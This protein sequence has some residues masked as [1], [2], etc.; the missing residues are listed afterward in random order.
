MC[1]FHP[2]YFQP[3]Y[4]QNIHETLDFISVHQDVESL[5]YLNKKLSNKWGSPINWLENFH[6]KTYVWL[7]GDQ[8]SHKI[9][10]CIPFFH[11]SLSVGNSAS[12]L[13]LTSWLQ[14]S[15]PS[16]VDKRECHQSELVASL[17][18]N[19]HG[20]SITPSKYKESDLAKIIVIELSATCYFSSHYSFGPCAKVINI[21]P[22]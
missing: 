7:G 5:K 10:I 13:G 19:H 4:H 17:Q 15:T 18:S 12:R 16:Y 3:S 21:A 14:K 20:L 11:Q 22:S 2:S 9:Y 1:S 8:V 6:S